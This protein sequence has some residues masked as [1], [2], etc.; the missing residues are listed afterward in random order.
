MKTEAEQA[1]LGTDATGGREGV[2]ELVDPDR[3]RHPRP[4]QMKARSMP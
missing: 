3:R 4:H 1:K 2:A